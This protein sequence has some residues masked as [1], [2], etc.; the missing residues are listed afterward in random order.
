MAIVAGLKPTRYQPTRWEIVI[1]GPHPDGPLLVAYTIRR[2]RSNL[3]HIMRD[4]REYLDRICGDA[5]WAIGDKAADGIRIGTEW[6][7]RYSGRTQRD[8][9]DSERPFIMDVAPR[10]ILFRSVSSLGK[11]GV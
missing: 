3:V 9:K 2:S 5:E 4:R 11:G 7:C 1:I 10:L 8:A 6:L